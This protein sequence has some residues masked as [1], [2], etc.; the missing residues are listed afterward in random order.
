M[1]ETFDEPPLTT[2]NSQLYFQNTNATAAMISNPA[3]A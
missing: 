3:A 2:H 1:L